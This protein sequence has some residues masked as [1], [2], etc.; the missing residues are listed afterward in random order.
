MNYSNSPQEEER[1]FNLMRFLL[2]AMIGG[3]IFL[4]PYARGLYYDQM[5][6]YLNLTP[7][8][9]GSVLAL[10]GTTST[11]GTFFSGVLADRYSAKWLLVI[12]LIAT[13]AGGF[14]L[15]S[16]PSYYGFMGLYILW[17]LSITFTYNSA[18]YKAIRYTGTADQQGK[19]YGLVG[20]FRKLFTAGVAFIGAAVF[21]AYAAS[22]AETEEQGFVM[23]MSLYTAIYFIVALAV[24]IFWKKDQPIAVEERWKLKDSIAVFKH[25]ATWY[26]GFIIYFVYGMDLSLYTILTPYM[27][28]VLGI[29][30]S[31]NV[32]L[33]AVRTY[34]FPFLGG[35]IFGLVLDK[36]ADKIR[37]CQ[38]AV[39]LAACFVASMLFIPI[40]GGFWHAVFFGVL[41][42]Y[43]MCN[44]GAYL[45]AF[46]LLDEADIPKK[47]T[48]SIIGVSISI[49]FL[50]DITMNYFSNW[51]VGTYG[52]EL[53]TRYV[54]MLVIVHGVIAIFLY[55][56]FRRYLRKY[57]SPARA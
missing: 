49:G 25:P 48:G 9:F 4:L 53:G 51:L 5:L 32:A 35:L 46:S 23:V 33:A 41:G 8:E 18:H 57:H 37:A 27:S 2:L 52:F 22:T 3:T 15:L 7:I 13:G 19:M 16:R 21:A 24:I 36:V 14:I 29:D 38:V 20:G 12:S 34:G 28:N 40:H 1:S 42:G 47:I 6:A 45:T 39:A 17:G 26:L 11:I 31:S 10:Y 55:S 43:I 56:M 30:S 44:Q 54:M 50:P